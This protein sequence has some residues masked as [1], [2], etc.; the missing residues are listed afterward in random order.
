MQT[1]DGVRPCIGEKDLPSQFQKCSD[2]LGEL[3]VALQAYMT[4]RTPKKKAEIA[5]E[6]MDVI[7]AV[8]TLLY[9]LFTEDEIDKAV[10]YTNAKNYVRGYNRE[11]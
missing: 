6:G 3:G 10:E 2:E 11:K 9:S 1:L 4:D 8:T 7:T 5:F